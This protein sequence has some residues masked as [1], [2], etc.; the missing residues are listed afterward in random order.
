MHHCCS[1]TTKNQT[2][3]NVYIYNLLLEAYLLYKTERK[4]SWACFSAE[5]S[6]HYQ[7]VGQ[8]P[9]QK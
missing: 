8:R 9:R 6:C 4:T 7:I 3:G 5:G 1:I 2:Q